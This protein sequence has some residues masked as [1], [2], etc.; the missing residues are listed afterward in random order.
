M[1]RHI[2]PQPLRDNTSIEETMLRHRAIEMADRSLQKSATLR[3]FLIEPAN[4]RDDRLR[5]VGQDRNDC[6]QQRSRR[7]T[8]SALF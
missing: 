3:R 8:T 6:E 4:V 1:R 2:Q 7:I 5:L